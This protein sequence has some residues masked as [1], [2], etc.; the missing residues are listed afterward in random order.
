MEYADKGDL[1]EEILKHQKIGEFI[2]EEF[3]W[4]VII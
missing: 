2:E 3:I 4:R 1:Y